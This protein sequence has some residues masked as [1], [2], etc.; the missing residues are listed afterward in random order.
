MLRTTK[1]YRY[2]EYV[3]K[4][5]H[6]LEGDGPSRARQL[7]ARL[8]YHAAEF[9]NYVGLTPQEL[10]LMYTILEIGVCQGDLPPPS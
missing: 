9:E 4:I 7:L 1:A 2:D 10:V 5:W 3:A 6:H 8:S